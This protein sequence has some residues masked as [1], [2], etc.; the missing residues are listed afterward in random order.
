MVTRTSGAGDQSNSAEGV[1]GTQEAT[2]SPDGSIMSLLPS[3]CQQGL[4]CR[5]PSPLGEA[6]SGGAV[7]TVL[8]GSTLRG[9]GVFSGQDAAWFERVCAH[10]FVPERVGAGEQ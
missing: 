7:T 6:V 8:L 5:T 3:I 2:L 10:L 1:Q 4:V 9:T